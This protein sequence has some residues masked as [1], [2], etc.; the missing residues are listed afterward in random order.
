MFGC[1][2]IYK[3]LNIRTKLGIDGDNHL[4]WVKEREGGGE[5]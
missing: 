1:I 2:L 5:K 3:V 4:C